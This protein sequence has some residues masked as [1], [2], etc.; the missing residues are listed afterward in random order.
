MSEARIGPHDVRRTLVV[1]PGLELAEAVDPAG[2]RLLVQVLRLR[3]PRDEELDALREL[4]RRLAK[5]TTRLFDSFSISTHAGFDAPDGTRVLFWALP[6]SGLTLLDPARSRRLS[7][8]ET[9]E[10]A[11]LL[12]ARAGRLHALGAFDPALFEGALLLTSAGV[13]CDVA[14][15]PITAPAAWLQRPTP[16]PRLLPEEESGAL[17]VQGDLHRISQVLSAISDSTGLS[18]ECRALLAKLADRAYPDLN[19]AMLEV[20][21][22]QDSLLQSSTLSRKS[23]PIP[24]RPMAPAVPPPP[25]EAPDGPDWGAMFGDLE[26]AEI[27]VVVDQTEPPRRALELVDTVKPSPP[28]PIA[29][30]DVI[31]ED[32]VW[33]DADLVSDSGSR[34]MPWVEEEAHP[35]TAARPETPPTPAAASA[36]VAQTHE[37][38]K[39]AWAP[40]VFTE[41]A[42][43]W[44][45]IVETQ[46]AHRRPTGSF[47]GY[48]ESL[49]GLV[50]EGILPS[51][52]VVAPMPPAPA[53]LEGTAAPVARP[54]EPV[55]PSPQLVSPSRPPRT[56][57]AP[58]VVAGVVAVL[59]LLGALA[60]FMRAKP[61]PIDALGSLVAGPT[62]QVSLES[63]PTGAKVVA[64][65]D[66]RLLGR[67]PLEFLVPPGAQAVVLVV[68]R[69]YEPQR[70]VLPDRGALGIRLLPLSS[71]AGCEV[72]LVAPEGIALEG[73][74]TDLSDS[75]PT[76]VPGSMVVR[77]KEGQVFAGARLVR[78]PELGGRSRQ[79]LRFDK[80]WA[81]ASL[82]ITAPAG[83]T[84]FVDEKP[85][86]S[87]PLTHKTSAAFSFVRVVDASARASERWVA[88]RT[89]TEVQMPA[90]APRSLEVTAGEVPE[91]MNE[92]GES[93]EPTPIDPI[94]EET[95]VR[96]TPVRGK[97]LSRV[98][99]ERVGK[100]LREGNR[101]LLSGQVPRAQLAFETCL[102]IDEGTAACHRSLGTLHRRQG[103]KKTARKHL[104]RYVE[105]APDAPDV[106]TI[107]R[108]LKTLN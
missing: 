22:L 91:D 30:L 47:P 13:P 100:L 86:G 73:L 76:E 59:V 19:A 46:G 82:R 8:A 58:K 3:A 88:T 105:L 14:G 45:E 98:D 83:T 31:D 16:A 40:P 81:P 18:A 36:S 49:P 74:E 2:R 102:K 42:S 33:A 9:L 44:S 25:A 32:P 6:W 89:E 107:R 24:S 51:S 48:E 28:S 20:R 104:L 80:R 106:P 17:S 84:A 66:G 23:E 87:V 21:R 26:D 35:P 95:A 77:A 41:G 50:P 69:G 56:G 90:P 29:D 68:A 62:N 97:R 12:L 78:C 39:A 27:P 108:I 53:A 67:T 101:L 7:E 38:Q 64:E 70:V 43:P 52:K 96:P 72:E 92:A 79:D 61:E 85:L 99:R 93:E 94:V 15:L 55:L 71:E 60:A 34:P 65:A 63:Q 54:L 4:E 10:T 5:L 103:D 75:P 57:G 1:G 11:R 37:V